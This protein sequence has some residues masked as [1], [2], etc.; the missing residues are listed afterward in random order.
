MPTALIADDEDLQR[1]EL[2]RLLAAVW[3]EL[4]VVAMCED[5]DEALE[6]INQFAP[7]VAF[8]DIRMPGI[9][10]LDVARASKGNCR[11]IFTTAYDGHAI[12]AFSLGAIDYLLKP[13][14]QERLAECVVRLREKISNGGLGLLKAMEDLD[15][16]LRAT[17]EPA[18]IK[19]IST[20]AGKVIKI[21]PIDEVLF[22]ESDT[23]YT[24]VV[25]ASDEGLVRMPLKELR[26]GLDPDLF[27]QISKS[28]LVCMRAIARARKDELGNIV[29][30]LRGHPEQLK[31]NKPYAWRFRSGA[32]S[33]VQDR[34]WEGD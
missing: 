15:R 28:T 32:D 16:R 5:G 20:T 26:N 34:D 31:V 1:S 6:A 17:Q 2:R 30:E 12:E 8:L 19:W 27:W 21:F 7:D 25:S 9:S 11:V 22:L 4:T 3:P 13:V 23:R 18:R 29:V 24:R 10:G 33:G 14:T